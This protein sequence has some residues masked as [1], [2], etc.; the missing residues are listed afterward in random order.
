MPGRGEGYSRSGDIQKRLQITGRVD[1]TFRHRV[2]LGFSASLQ[3]GIA[4]LRES[5]DASVIFSRKHSESFC[6]ER[7]VDCDNRVRL[8]NWKRRPIGNR[9]HA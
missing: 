4:L 3:T 8:L 9:W 6:S 5:L 2:Y 7:T 1:L